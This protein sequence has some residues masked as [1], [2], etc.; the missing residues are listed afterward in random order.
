M[1]KFG[2][3][4]MGAMALASCASIMH[5]TGQDV[6]ISS[7]PVGA[8]VTVDDSSYGSTPLI[9]HLR[10][11]N[12]HTIRISLDGYQPFAMTTT[13]KTSGWVWGNI[14]F[15]GLIGLVVDASNGAIYDINPD[16]VSATLAKNVATRTG[17]TLMIS[18]VLHADPSWRRIGALEHR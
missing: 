7:Q 14:V 3:C 16:I 13:Q 10:R 1:V 4:F 5:G 17:S 6:S 8:N 2:A 12:N 11:K 18:V 9:A 15:G